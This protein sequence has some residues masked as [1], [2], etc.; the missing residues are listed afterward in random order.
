M[1]VSQLIRELEDILKYYG[2]AHV[3]MRKDGEQ[4]DLLEINQV[5]YPAWET[6]FEDDP[7]VLDGSPKVSRIPKMKN[8]RPFQ[9]TVPVLFGDERL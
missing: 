3:T 6:R 8:P 9:F 7:V 1:K 5:Y 2:D 4:D